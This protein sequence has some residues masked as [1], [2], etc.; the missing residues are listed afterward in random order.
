MEG[1]LR[2]SSSIPLR[3]AG[4][5]QLGPRR[6]VQSL[7]PKTSHFPERGLLKRGLEGTPKSVRRKQTVWS[8]RNVLFSDVDSLL[9]GGPSLLESC[10]VKLTT[11]K[12]YAKR[13]NAF[14]TFAEIPDLLSAGLAQLEM[15][16]LEFFDVLYLGGKDVGEGAKLL[17]ALGYFRPELRQLS[18]S[19]LLPR[20]RLALQG[21][22]RLAPTATR[23]PL[24]WPVLAGIVVAL[25]V[26]GH[27]QAALASVLAADAYLRPGELLYLSTDD[28]SKPEPRFSSAFHAL[29][30]VLFPKER[31]RPSK[32]HQFDDSVLLDSKGREWINR[33]LVDPPLRPHV[34]GV[35]LALPGSCPAPWPCRLDAVPLRSAT[36]GAVPRLPREVPDVGRHSA[37]GTVGRPVQREALREVGEGHG[38]AQ[39]GASGDSPLSRGRR[40]A[41]CGLLREASSPP[42]VARAPC[43]QAEAHDLRELCEPPTLR[44]PRTRNLPGAGPP[45]LRGA[46]RRVAVELF[47]GSGRWSAA[48][49]GMDWIA[50][51]VDVKFGT[52]HDLSTK[53]GQK[54]AWSLVVQADFVHIGIPCATFSSAT[55]GRCLRSRAH[56]MG[57]PHLSD[58][59]LAKVQLHN[60]LLQFSIRVV[61]YCKR[62][63]IPL[64][65]ENPNS[66]KIWS[67][68]LLAPLSKDAHR[69]VLDFCSMGTAYRKRTCFLTWNTKCLCFLNG[70]RCNLVDHNCCFS[71]EEHRILQG[72]APGGL[73]WTALAQ[74]YPVKLC[75]MIAK[76]ID[77]FFDIL[78]I[79]QKQKT[80]KR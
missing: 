57:K 31:G 43:E 7:D 23:L 11:A 30:L 70:Y 48:M 28:L 19:G 39:Q 35:A 17:S 66:S 25:L 75:R 20:A 9:E 64:S 46:R 53:G 55:R 13:K 78:S 77:D 60:R 58:A 2:R 14:I 71:G 37:K 65:L 67:N 56:P 22:G 73:P 40:P 72:R 59:D 61:K 50:H 38:T 51:E 74:A 15:A 80:Q 69:C 18:R 79:K 36:H 6:R 54:W 24:P 76:S 32:T 34:Q 62:A 10:A 12:D 8:F 16:L 4:S 3:S 68:P 29:A 47:S 26:M 44:P 42:C 1:P 33:L 63:N 45:S 27:P 41:P 5:H 49:R 52:T 21:W